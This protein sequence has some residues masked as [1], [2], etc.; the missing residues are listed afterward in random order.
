MNK[1]R[2]ISVRLSAAEVLEAECKSVRR[3][4]MRNV[5]L[6]IKMSSDERC[7]LILIHQL[8]DQSLRSLFTQKVPG[9]FWVILSSYSAAECQIWQWEW[10]MMVQWCEWRTVM[11]TYWSSSH[12]WALVWLSCSPHRELLEGG[13]PS[14]VSSHWSIAEK[15]LLG[16]LHSVSTTRKM[17][18]C[19]IHI[20]IRSQRRCSFSCRGNTERED[21]ADPP[22]SVRLMS[23]CCHFIITS[24]SKSTNITS[25]FYWQLEEGPHHHHPL[26][27]ARRLHVES[28]SKP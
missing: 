4:W 7:C 22:S 26:Q 10:R 23:G 25:T 20:I 27:T 2:W 21:A 16:E 18:S 11:D 6:F 5:L 17:F 3:Q 19:W 24:L 15:Q 28:K 1:E 14:S 8:T 9:S 13:A 12:L